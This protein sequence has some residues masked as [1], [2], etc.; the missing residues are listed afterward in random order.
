MHGDAP[1]LELLR[2]L[3][4]GVRVLPPRLRRN[5]ADAQARPAELRL[6]VDADGLGAELSGAD[7]RRVAAGPPAQD[8]NVTFHLSQPFR[9]VPVRPIL[10]R[11]VLKAGGRLLA[12]LP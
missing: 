12:A 1:L 10:A 3:L 6:A 11:L 9:S 7:R 4:G 5:A 8:G 2:E